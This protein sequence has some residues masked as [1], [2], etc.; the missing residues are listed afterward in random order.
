M[1]QPYTQHDKVTT[2]YYLLL[3]YF[4]S[5][6]KMLYR[7]PEW[8]EYT[9]FQCKMARSVSL[10]RIHLLCVRFKF[11]FGYIRKRILY[12][13]E[14]FTYAEL[15]DAVLMLQVP[16]SYGIIRDMG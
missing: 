4:H 14:L 16:P 11:Q 12:S 9:H 5:T 10:D 15:D 7:H 13:T 6:P 1:L 2:E 8:Q 3:Y